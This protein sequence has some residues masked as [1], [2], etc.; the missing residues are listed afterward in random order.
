[1]K[2]IVRRDELLTQADVS[3]DAA[4]SSPTQWPTAMSA[5]SS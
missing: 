4:A 3:G 1:M 2:R 5:R